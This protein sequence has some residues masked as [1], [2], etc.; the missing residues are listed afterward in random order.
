MIDPSLN[1]Q[2]VLQSILT[3]LIEQFDITKFSID[4]PI[5][6]SDIQ[7]LIFTTPGVLSI[8]NIEFKNL[9]GETNGRTYSSV[10]YDVKSNLRKGILYPPEGGIFEIKYPDFDIIGRTA[11]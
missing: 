4:Q 7:N 3:K 6:L 10:N 5:V 11:L 2:T 8:I 1:Q 9:N